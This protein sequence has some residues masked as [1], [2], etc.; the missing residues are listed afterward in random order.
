MS[1]IQ[2]LQNLNEVL[3]ALKQ[4]KAYSEID[5][6]QSPGFSCTKKKQKSKAN[7]QNLKLSQKVQK[8]TEFWQT[9]D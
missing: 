3:I 9:I 4:D 1:K 6:V 7:K 8:M 5:Y 2:R